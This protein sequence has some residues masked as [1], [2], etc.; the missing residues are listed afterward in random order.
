M[1]NS[2]NKSEQ[3]TENLASTNTLIELLERTLKLEERVERQTPEDEAA[4]ESL[5][6]TII[7]HKTKKENIEK[8]LKAIH[9]MA[10]PKTRK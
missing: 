10:S 8:K 2:C 5:K 3:L 7:I 6:A 9:N 4:I 1:A